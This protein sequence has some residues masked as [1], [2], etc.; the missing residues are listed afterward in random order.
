MKRL[1]LIISGFVVFMQY[2][3][4]QNPDEWAGQQLTQNTITTAVPFLN[5]GPDARSGGMGE[6]GAG[7][8]PDAISM[9]W[10]PAKY[11]FIDKSFGFSV[12]YSPWLK[13][14]VPDIN[15]AYLTGYVK[16][17]DKQ[18]VAGSLKFFSLGDIAFTDKDG[19][20]YMNARPNEFSI[21]GTY[22]R[23]FSRKISGAVA[24]RFIYSNLTQGQEVEGTSTKPG[25]SVAADVAMFYKTDM[26]IGWLEYS[27]FAFGVN[28]SN[29]GA[30]ISYSNDD[31]FKDFI[32]TNF[33][34][35]PSWLLGIDDY[36]SIRF[37]L[38]IN[39]LLVPTPPIYAV[40][41]AGKPIY[42][43]ANNRVIWKGMDP[44][45]SV[46]QGMVQSWYDAPG[47]FS[48]EMK[49]FIWVVGMEYWY[50][51]QFSVRGGYFHESKM[52]GG[53]QFFTLGVGL[54]YNVFGLDFSYLIPTDQ[55]NPL[56]NTLRFTLT[57]DFD[58]INKASN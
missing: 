8:E 5:I 52:K 37:S 58:K 10:N 2:A 12:S 16:I 19:F 57:F 20:N 3:S 18:T 23:K 25:T 50:A 11:A 6:L 42:D 49:E 9:H 55:Q 28:I 15:L 33:R 46:V 22:S 39:K 14:L 29:I 56:A 1:L 30:K 27:E 26:N 17:D 40:D 21:D 48:E 44:N 47:G 13:K 41:S 7:T 36:N 53:R 51:N 43:D 4:A 38:D 34:I 24:V 35:G 31:L 45:V 32:P 54:R